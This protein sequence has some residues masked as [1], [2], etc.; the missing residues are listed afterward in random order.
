MIFFMPLL[1]A[2]R[3]SGRGGLEITHSFNPE[4]ILFV[5]RRR[6]AGESFHA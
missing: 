6:G 5:F 4:L 1:L 3:E 2:S